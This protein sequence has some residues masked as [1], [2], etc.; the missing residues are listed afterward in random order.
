MNRIVPSIET[1]VSYEI[2]SFKYQKLLKYKFFYNIIFRY[3]CR[4]CTRKY[5]AYIKHEMNSRLDERMKN[6]QGFGITFS[7]N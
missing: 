5:D 4:K 1:F 2:A 6:I 7:A 3:I